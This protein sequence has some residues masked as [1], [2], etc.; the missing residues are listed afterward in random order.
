M[1]EVKCDRNSCKI[2]EMYGTEKEV[3]T[4][5]VMASLTLFELAFQT[6]HTSKKNQ[7][8]TLKVLKEGFVDTFLKEQDLGKNLKKIAL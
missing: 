2:K 3:I 7:K 5:I 4:D 1:I 6:Y 8:A